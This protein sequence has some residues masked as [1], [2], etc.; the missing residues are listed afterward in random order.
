MWKGNG[1]VRARQYE[2]DGQLLLPCSRVSQHLW[3]DGGERDEERDG[4]R[5]EG[6]RERCGRRGERG[7]DQG[8][9]QDS[10]MG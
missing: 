1:R 6:G 5:D 9:Y 2:R 3:C 7:S 10:Q 8:S 4:E